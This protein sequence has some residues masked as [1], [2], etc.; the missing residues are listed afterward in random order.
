[1][2]SRKDSGRLLWTWAVILIVL[3][4]LLL[5]GNL[6]Y[7]GANWDVIWRLWPLILVY[8][9]LVRILEYLGV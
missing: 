5:L 7:G 1:M 4:A 2:E 8:S 9:G 6:G 3:G